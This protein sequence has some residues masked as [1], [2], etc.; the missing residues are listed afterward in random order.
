ML[1]SG[2]SQVANATVPQTVHPLGSTRIALLGEYITF[3]CLGLLLTKL[4]SDAHQP[5]PE[6][7][8]WFQAYFETLVANANPAL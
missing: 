8:T 7:G 5:A 3:K 6:A 4:R 1:L 2:S